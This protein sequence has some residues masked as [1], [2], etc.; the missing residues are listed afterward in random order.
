MAL[1]YLIDENVK[2][3]YPFELRRRQLNLVVWVIGE[4]GTPPKG[5]LDPNILL[6]CEQHGFVLV[7]NI[8]RSMPVHLADHTAQGCHVPGIILLNP[9]LGIGRNLEELIVIALGSF[10]DEYQDRIVHLP[11]LSVG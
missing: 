9:N 2:P 8:R 3:A 10:D 1:N 4:P 7:T 11:L 5:T 6:W